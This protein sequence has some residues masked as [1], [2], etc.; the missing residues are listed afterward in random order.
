MGDLHERFAD[1]EG[2]ADA[3]FGF[4]QA[5]RGEILTE[6]SVL[7]IQGGQG[8]TPV[9]VGKRNFDGLGDGIQPTMEVSAM[10]SGS[11]ERQDQ[12]A[13]DCER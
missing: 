3:R 1:A 9:G 4:E 12:T 13:A 6:R 7:E 2:V 5:E 10:K 11:S 8:G